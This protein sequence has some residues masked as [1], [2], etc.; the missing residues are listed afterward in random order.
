MKRL[1]V[2]GRRLNAACCRVSALKVA[3][4]L[5]LQE[6]LEKSRDTIFYQPAS[7]QWQ[8]VEDGILPI[9]EGMRGII[10]ND[11][12]FVHIAGNSFLIEGIK[13]IPLLRGRHGI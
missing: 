4:S 6:I 2:S 13:Q 7:A 8:C 10:W 1:E 11:P 9:T 5:L 3:M 12:H